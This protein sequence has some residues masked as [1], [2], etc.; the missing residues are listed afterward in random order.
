MKRKI[1]TL[2]VSL[3]MIICTS[4]SAL[5]ATSDDGTATANISA[6]A[7]S[8]TAQSMSL[9]C[10]LNGSDQTVYD[11]DTSTW[12]SEDATGSGSGWHVTIAATNFTSGADSIAVANFKVKVDDANITV[13]S[14][15][16]KPTSNITSYTSLNT[17]AMTLLTAAAGDGMG[18][19]HFVPDFS[20][21]VAA[22]TTVHNDYTSTVTVSIISGP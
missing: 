8:V 11:T 19:Y 5:A 12:V 17:T 20:L 18:V 2:I 4:G 7:L 13:S 16:T 14:G 10:T 15:N 22:D 3:I 21:D 9:A 1:L 6:G